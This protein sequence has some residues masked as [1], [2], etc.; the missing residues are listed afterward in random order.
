MTGSWWSGLFGTKGAS[1]HDRHQSVV[2][3]R[4]ALF[5]LN[6]MVFDYN[7]IVANKQKCTG[8][9]PENVRVSVLP[10]S[11]IDLT[12][13]YHGIEMPDLAPFAGA[14]FPFT[15][16]P[17]LAE[18]TV[19]MVGNPSLS[20]VEAFLGLMG[21]FG[22]ATGAAATAVTVTDRVEPSR[23]ADQDILVIGPSSLASAEQFFADAPVRYEG[24]GLK[25]AQRSPLQFIDALFSNRDQAN[26]EDVAAIVQNSRGFPASPVSA[27][28]M[29]M[30]APWS[31]CWPMMCAICLCWSMACPMQRSMPRF[32]AIFR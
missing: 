10:E 27:R 28:P 19:V 7:L 32:T 26:P 9:L 25:V 2:L 20:S 13:A 17:D 29:P 6:E 22:D 30:I 15:V 18:T 11:V 31:P 8:M 12:S 21:R 24:N 4:Y 3:P 23:L 14:G 1:S 16:R 5:G